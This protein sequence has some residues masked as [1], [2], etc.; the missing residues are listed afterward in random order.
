M[1]KLP[2]DQSM[3]MTRGKGITSI[4]DNKEDFDEDV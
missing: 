3:T 2:S 4:S 1:V